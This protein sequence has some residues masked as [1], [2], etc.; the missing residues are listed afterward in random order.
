MSIIRVIAGA[1]LF[2]LAVAVQAACEAPEKPSLPDGNSADEAAMIEGQ[3]TVRS[4][5]E[6]SN[7]Y[8]D[9]LVAEAK[10]GEETD[11]ADMKK[12]RLDRYNSGVDSMQQVADQFNKELRE[13]KARQ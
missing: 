1:G 8:L 10:E 9:C 11:D 6:K 5:V 3:T 12:E 7:A 13:Y 4:F 2:S